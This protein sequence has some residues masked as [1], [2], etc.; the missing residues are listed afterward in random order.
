VGDQ[1]IAEA[2]RAHRALAR[3]G[4][5]LALALFLTV[6]SIGLYQ[7]LRNFWLYR[8]FPP[9]SDPAFVTTKGTLETISVTSAAL[10]GRT[11]QVLVYLPPG[12]AAHPLRRY[13]V[14]YL[15]H[16]TPGRPTAFLLT[17]RMGVVEDIAT[18][19][20]RAQ[21]LILVLPY[22]STGT[23]TDTEWANGYRANQNWETF[24]AR[25]VV[26]A[27]DSQ[28]RTIPTRAGRAIG[29]L[30]EGGY[31]ALNI[32]LHHPKEFSVLESWSGYQRADRLKSI[33]GDN[34]R[35]LAWNS[36]LTRLPAVAR[37][38]R[39]QHTYVWLYWGASDRL[40]AQNELFARE[41]AS[42]GIPHRAFVVAGGHNWALWRGNAASAYVVAA[43]R[44]AHG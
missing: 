16:G 7:Y 10:G 26:N 15:L 14:F 30:S 29:G 42:A 8:G 19:R 40:R 11:Q 24:M 18:A 32:G 9:P 33:F 21:P 6:G 43:R 20:H 2:L 4:V 28:Y 22:G 17:V 27:I 23:F 1:Y 25:D 3:A 38:L 31:A 13:P 35:R 5:A 12:Y 34:A 36:P 39:R 41:L 44:L 37:T